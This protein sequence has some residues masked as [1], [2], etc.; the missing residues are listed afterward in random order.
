MLKSYMKSAI[1]NLVRHKWYTAVNVIGLSMGI[2]CIIVAYIVIT[3]AANYDGFHA[4]ADSIYRVLNIIEYRDVNCPFGTVPSPVGPRLRQDCPQVQRL[5]R[6][7]YESGSLRYQDKVFYETALFADNDFHSMFSF[8][9]AAGTVD[10]HNINAILISEDF[11]GKY[12][13]DANPIG[14]IMTFTFAGD[15]K[16]E[17]IVSGIVAEYPQNSSIR[18][19]VLGSINLLIEVGIEKDE[20]W[21]SV[22]NN[23]FIQVNDRASLPLVEQILNG[24]VS[25]ETTANPQST[26]RGYELVPLNRVAETG[27]NIFNNYL[28]STTPSSFVY[29]ISISALLILLAACFNYVNTVL[30]S[31]SRRFKEIGLRK[32]MG[33]GRVQLITQLLSEQIIICVVALILG[34]CL[35][36]IL[37]PALNNL[38]SFV[39]LS[40][41]HTQ[42]IGFALFLLGVVVATGVGA[43]LY[44]AYVIAS[45]SPVSI[46]RGKQQVY[47]I[48]MVTGVLMGLQ[49][50][51]CMMGIIGSIVFA[52]NAHYFRNLDLGYETNAVLNVLVPNEQV[53]TVLKNEIQNHP[54]I[55]GLAGS[56]INIGPR[57]SISVYKSVDEQCEGLLYIVGDN[58]IETMKLRLREGRGFQEQTMSDADDAVVIN[59]SMVT[60]MGWESASGKTITTGN[61]TYHVIG[62]VDDFMNRSIQAPIMPAVFHMCRPERYRSMQ[63][64]IHPGSLAETYQY[65][66]AAWAR[67]FPELPFEADWQDYV[68]AEE[69]QVSES[70]NKTMTAA[71]LMTIAIAIM[72]LYAIVSA[73][74]ARRTKEIGIRK[75]LGASVA[76]IIGLVS[77]ELAILLVAAAVVADIAGYYAMKT[78][79]ESI[80]TYH[81]GISTLA[82]LSS[83]LIIVLT[84]AITIGWHVWKTATANPVNSLKY[85]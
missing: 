60:A 64:R 43:G 61:K 49:F 16:R 29:G 82:L 74:V 35:A 5:T 11:A 54:G 57:R 12:F 75:V 78:L 10:S 42:D 44:P 63:I 32:V 33:G 23:L 71:A 62:V 70:I 81:T 85:E 80:W 24:Y 37:V 72:G 14:A 36:E 31:A 41:R 68:I 6:L 18:F 38:Y 4:N 65:L 66:Q 28:Y 53:F 84:A 17:L 8:T 59:E 56:Y 67:I 76:H 51:L 79:M 30:A 15:K 19:D 7:E 40:I 22:I 3:Y 25:L 2:A 39:K 21:T 50:T 13:G 58:Y 69:I 26:S 45:C 83:N 20:D 48:G 55:A 34:L 47:K 52:R 27:R 46:F 1:R 73:N 77:R 9:L